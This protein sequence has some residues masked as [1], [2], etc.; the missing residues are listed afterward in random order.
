MI[1]LG[2]SSNTCLSGF[3]NSNESVTLYNILDFSEKGSFI[4]VSCSTVQQFV[5]GVRKRVINY[6][7]FVARLQLALSDPMERTIHPVSWT[8]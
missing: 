8:K 7:F 1:D 5:C 6:S 2:R 3:D 4:V